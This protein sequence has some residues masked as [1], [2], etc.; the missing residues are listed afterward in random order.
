MS[1][2]NVMQCQLRATSMGTR[3]TKS[4]LRPSWAFKRKAHHRYFRASPI[5][6]RGA[7]YEVAAAGDILD[8][9]FI[10]GISLSIAVNIG[11]S[12]LPLLVEPK[13]AVKLKQIRED[14]SQDIKWG[15]MSILSFFPL[16]NWLVNSILPVVMQ[17][18]CLVLCH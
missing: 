5:A 4:R 16:L 9:F 8:V 6:A 10:S 1:M 14:D 18:T 17:D 2:S 3:G 13:D 15:V 12:A 11:V 7:L